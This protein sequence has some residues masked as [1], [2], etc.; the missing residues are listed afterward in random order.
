MNEQ[1]PARARQLWEQGLRWGE[2]LLNAIFAPSPERL[3]FRFNDIF[4]GLWLA[5]L[6]L[7]GLYLWGIFYS[8]GEISLDFLDWAE[9]TGP[10]YALLKDAVTRGQLPLHA[11]NLTALR[12]VTDRYFA[13]PDTPFSP[14]IF[15]LRYLRIGQYLFL[16]TV[17]FYILGFIGLVILARR[18]RLSPLSF[19]LL[20]LL[21]NF[22][23]IPTGH[24]AVGHSIYTAYFLLPYFVLLVLRLLKREQVG[25]KWVLGFAVLELVILMQGLFHLYLWCLMFLGLLVVFNVR[26]LKPVALGGIFAGLVG[27]P[28]LLPPILVL[29][30]IT[31]EFLGGPATLA[32]LFASLVVLKD[33]DRVMTLPSQ[34]FPLRWWEQDY[35]IGLLGLAILLIFGVLVPLWRDRSRKS[36]QV[37]LLVACLIFTVLSIGQV[38]GAILRFA[39]LP[40]FTGERVS[41]RFFAVPLA[42][43]LVLAAIYLQSELNHRKL[44]AWV[45]VLILGLCGLLYHDLSQHLQAW[46]I[47]Y[48]DGLVYLFPKVP[49]VAA[50]H[51]IQN[52]ADPIYISMLVGGSIVALLALAFLVVMVL[53]SERK[54]GAGPTR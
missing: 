27:L 11:A 41:A 49:F 25:W 42:C 52:H 29:K 46:R 51:T 48:L 32:D 12:G 14:Q 4:S 33:P 2:K 13:I 24:L 23:G 8:W 20:F 15:L 17:L 16:D 40:P 18:Y 39:P 9:V 38:F 43:L 19:S 21:F 31:H 47:R 7:F 50:Q 10:R 36:V 30:G 22:N 54:A 53:R 3:A 26:L 35:Y 34:I 37:Q 28:R 6:L 44:T 45:Q 5:G 1:K